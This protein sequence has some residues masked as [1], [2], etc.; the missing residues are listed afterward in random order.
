MPANLTPAEQAR[1]AE[2]EAIMAPLKAE[3]A[4]ILNRARQRRHY[5]AKTGPTQS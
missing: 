5:A 4:A 1:L 3:K 2:I